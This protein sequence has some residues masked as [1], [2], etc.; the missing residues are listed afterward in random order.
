VYDL[1]IAAVGAVTR[2]ATFTVVVADATTLRNAVGVTASG[3]RQSQRFWKLRVPAGQK[4]LTFKVSGG[5][6]DTDLYVRRSNAPTLTQYECRPYKSGNAESCVFNAPA[7]GT[8]YVMLQGFDS[9]SKVQLSG[10]Y[11][12]ATVLTNNRSVT[13]LAAPAGAQTLW[14]LTV[15]PAQKR[16]SFTLAG[17]NGNAD[18]YV[19]F[20]AVP[21]TRTYACKSTK[22]A[23]SEVCTLTTPAA[24]TYYVM[25][26]GR[27]AYR[28]VALRGSYSR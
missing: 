28:N 2:T 10:R 17:G 14:K 5:T 3:A 20:R 23:S 18:L 19:R 9:Y 15:P 7:A 6:G 13:P 1:T 4:S 22:S 8:W 25:V 24:G 21:T 12:N 11:D 27:T 16:V 26:R